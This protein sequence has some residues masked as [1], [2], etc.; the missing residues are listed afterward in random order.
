MAELD[1]KERFI[2]P[3]RGVY[4][5]G[6]TVELLQAAAISGN[7]ILVEPDK[8][9]RRASVVDEGR[10]MILDKLPDEPWSVS[11]GKFYSNKRGRKFMSQEEL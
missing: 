3:I 11:Q 2:L 9:E 1:N 4:S 8:S 10:K 5:P 6:D 7:I